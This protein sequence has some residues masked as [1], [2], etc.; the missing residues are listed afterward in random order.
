MM[1]EFGWCLSN[2]VRVD[3]I[4]FFIMERN[5]DFKKKNWYGF[6]YVFCEFLLLKFGFGFI[7]KG[8]LDGIFI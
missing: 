7:N 3:V 1:N 5:C 4:N 2:C 6:C 8:V